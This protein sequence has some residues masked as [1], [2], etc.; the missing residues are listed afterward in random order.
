[1]TGVIVETFGVGM[2]FVVPALGW[3]WVALHLRS[4][5]IDRYEDRLPLTE[6]GLDEG[7]ALGLRRLAKEVEDQLGDLD[8]PFVPDKALASPEP[9]RKEMASVDV[10]L[11]RR[12]AVAWYYRCLRI[13]GPVLLGL[14]LGYLTLS[15][16]AL[17]YFAEFNRWRVG[18]YIGLWGTI[19]MAALA[20]ITIGCYF[21][22]TFRF[23]SAWRLAKKAQ[24]P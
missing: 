21:I 23:D 4:N 11:R 16:M 2:I 3:L 14:A 6:A 20:G 5:V 12:A 9:L 1:M 18:G 13:C 17:S 15:S 22:L 8:A 7:A 24:R 10:L 19:S